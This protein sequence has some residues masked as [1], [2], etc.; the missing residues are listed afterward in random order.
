MSNQYQRNP[1][2]IS[3]DFANTL[4]RLGIARERAIAGR[5]RPHV[6]KDLH[7][8]RHTFVYLAAEAGMPLPLVQAI[9]G[10]S[11]QQMTERYARHATDKAKI[12]HMQ[13]LPDF[14]GAPSSTG[15]LEDDSDAAR[16]SRAISV[17]KSRKLSAA[18]ARAEALKI[19]NGKDLTE[20]K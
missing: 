7:S 5:S 13:R 12:K 9:V 6:F 16:I 10:H 1:T 15:A 17:L 18:E 11:S 4:D 19:L 14:L 8:F 2:K 20:V 3:R